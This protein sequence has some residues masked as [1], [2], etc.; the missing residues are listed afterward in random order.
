VA[1]PSLPN[2]VVGRELATKSWHM[3]VRVNHRY[4]ASATGV[5]QRWIWGTEEEHVRFHQQQQNTQHC[6]LRLGSTTGGNGTDSGHVLPVG[7]TTSSDGAVARRE[8]LH[9]A[10]SHRSLRAYF[11]VGD[12]DTSQPG[13][14]PDKGHGVASEGHTRTHSNDGHT[15]THSNDGHTRTLSNE[16]GGRGERGHKRTSS[17]GM[18]HARSTSNGSSG[19]VKGDLGSAFRSS[20]TSSSATTTS[21]AML[22][23]F[24][25]TTQE[26][27]HKAGING[28]VVTAK[29][30]FRFILFVWSGSTVVL[31]R[32]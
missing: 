31:A 26:T 21:P 13:S 1:S 4:S 32:L 12:V 19:W 8:G 9:T 5:V 24:E 28:M 11:G 2:I 14:P 25:C 22:R 29:C 16:S 30:V 20:S 23:T 7:A 6:A 18:S 17:F 27:V 15:R 3:G 10:G